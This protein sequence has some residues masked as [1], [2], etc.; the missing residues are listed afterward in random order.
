MEYSFL[1]HLSTQIKSIAIRRISIQQPYGLALSMPRRS[2]MSVTDRRIFTDGILDTHVVTRQ[3]DTVEWFQRFLVRP[4]RRG[5]AYGRFL[6]PV[7]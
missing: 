6:F 2:T 7:G 4:I 5:P 3:E 1:T